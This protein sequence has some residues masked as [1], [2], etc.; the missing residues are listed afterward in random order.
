MLSHIG[1]LASFC[2]NMPTVIKSVLKEG[3]T[4][5]LL[6]N[7]T[8]ESGPFSF[9]GQGEL[10]LLLYSAAPVRP[11]QPLLGRQSQT[12]IIRFPR[13]LEGQHC[14]H[15]QRLVGRHAVYVPS[16]ESGPKLS[17]LCASG[18]FFLQ[19]FSPKGVASVATL[20]RGYLD[21]SQV[22]VATGGRV[23]RAPPH[24]LNYLQMFNLLLCTNINTQRRTEPYNHT[25]IL[26]PSY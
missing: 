9:P 2:P 10:H 4:S 3:L 24:R 19:F 18:V 7:P 17:A 25:Q 1:P 16:W 15:V 8:S 21:D 6:V 12:R 22:A 11:G 23:F 5:H 13:A 14:P 20:G 26:S